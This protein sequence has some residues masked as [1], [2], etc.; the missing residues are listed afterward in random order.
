MATSNEVLSALKILSGARL[1]NAPD[2]DAAPVVVETWKSVMADIPGEYLLQAVNDIVIEAEFWPTI[3][4]VRAA[5][6]Q[7]KAHNGTSA[8]VNHFR[9]LAEPV[10]EWQPSGIEKVKFP[11]EVEARIDA[12]EEKYYDDGLPTDEELAE[13][14]ALTRPIIAQYLP[15]AP[16]QEAQREAVGV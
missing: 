7:V 4:Q 14:D 5:A 8:A 10:I 11:P 1:R 9:P 2:R 6:Y 3:K 15:Y 16:M 12:L 13:I